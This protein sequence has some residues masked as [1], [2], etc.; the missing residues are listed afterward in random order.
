MVS[1]SSPASLGAALAQSPGELIG[2]RVVQ[3]A[4]AAAMIP[5]LLATFRVIFSGESAGKAFGLYG[6]ILGKLGGALGVAIVGT[7]FFSELEHRSFTGAFEHA[8][9]VVVALFLAAGALALLLPRT[10]VGEEA[11]ADV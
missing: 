4:A 9:P 1:P 8:V 5:Q 11:V 7:V 10:A 3:G 6:A 2:A